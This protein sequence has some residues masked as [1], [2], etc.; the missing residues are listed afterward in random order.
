VH[1]K[2]V[3]CGRLPLLLAVPIRF[4]AAVLS[5][6]FCL[7]SR[8]FLHLDTFPFSLW[9]YL[10]CVTL[11]ASD[12]IYSLVILFMQGLQ[13]PWCLSGLS[14]LLWKSVIGFI[15]LQVGHLLSMPKVYMREYNKS[16]IYYTD[17]RIQDPICSLVRESILEPDLL[18]VS[19]SL[20]P[21][22]FGHNVV[23]EGERSYPTM[24]RQ[25]IA[26]LEVSTAKY[27]FFCEHDVL[28]HKSHFDFIPP[29]D[30]IFYYNDN[31]WRWQLGSDT[32][33]RHDR[34]LSLSSLCANREFVL[35]HHKRRL[36]TIVERGWEKIKGG[37]PKWVRRLG[38]E[39]GLKKKKRGGFSDDEFGTW[40]SKRP[41]I[42][43]RHKGTFSSP[44]TKLENFTHKPKW[45][46]EIPID[47]IKGW[48]LEG[49]L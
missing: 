42:D 3:G 34:M 33:I 41:C 8:L 12:L 21:I 30:D 15:I 48:D 17:N 14:S 28:Y 4:L 40:S 49:M 39:P 32:A 2:E 7:E 22:D 37:E 9:W 5:G 31:V 20:K 46:R 18:I 24:V 45:W 38:Y 25:I 23:V 11:P 44:K 43:I 10:F 35:S 27:V 6:N 29:R 1:L 26:A 36:E 47:E 19:A 16:I 13:R